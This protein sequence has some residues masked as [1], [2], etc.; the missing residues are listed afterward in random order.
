MRQRL[1]EQ[2]ELGK[3]WTSL[4]LFSCLTHATPHATSSFTGQR[5]QTLAYPIPLCN[6]CGVLSLAGWGGCIFSG[7]FCFVHKGHVIISLDGSNT[8]NAL[9]SKLE[10]CGVNM[11]AAKL[12]TW[13]PEFDPQESHY[14]RR[15]SHLYYGILVSMNTQWM[16]AHTKIHREI[17]VKQ[18]EK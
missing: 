14:G 2:L 10:E 15:K 7:D 11:L 4:T 3:D 8:D 17:N 12:G 6:N 16:H 1:A 9:N 5:L 13:Q 18:Y